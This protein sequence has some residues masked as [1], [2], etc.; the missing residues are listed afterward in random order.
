VMDHS[1]Q[2]TAHV[3]QDVGTAERTGKPL[4]ASQLRQK[5]KRT[6]DTDQTGDFECPPEHTATTF[7][8][9]LMH[10]GALEKNPETGALTCPIPSFQSYILRRGGLD[11]AALEQTMNA[12]TR[13]S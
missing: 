10:C 7:I 1:P 9:H 13:N 12:I 5:I 4:N 8:T 2:L 11:P 3:L 6:C